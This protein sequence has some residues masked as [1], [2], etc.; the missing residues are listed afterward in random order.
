MTL[1]EALRSRRIPAEYRTACIALLRGEP[2]A[3]NL[4]SA[5]RGRS[6]TDA[7]LEQIETEPLAFFE[8]TE[9]PL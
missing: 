4:L 3:R 2:Y 6:V 9:A 5:A 7:E 1:A 8:P